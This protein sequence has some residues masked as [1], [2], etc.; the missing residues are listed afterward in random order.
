MDRGSG[1][2]QPVGPA[3]FLHPSARSDDE[4]PAGTMGNAT[5]ASRRPRH[6]SPAAPP[7]TDR[8][9]LHRV[10]QYEDSR[11]PIHLER[12]FVPAS[13]SCGG[14][15]S[16]KRASTAG[17]TDTKT[18]VGTTPRSRTLPARTSRRG[19]AQTATARGRRRIRRQ[20][21]L[22]RVVAAA[23]RPRADARPVHR[24][25]RPRENA[26]RL[27]SAAGK[28]PGLAETLLPHR[29]RKLPH[30]AGVRASRPAAAVRAPPARTR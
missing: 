9:A 5:G 4:C 27:G 3:L 8:G 12:C 11:W 6:L 15:C 1:L 20:R 19:R 16:P 17:R 28:A 21:R 10:R 29:L 25:Q 7:F 26:A 18:T 14:S 22:V 13:R 2:S 24:S 23:P 30:P